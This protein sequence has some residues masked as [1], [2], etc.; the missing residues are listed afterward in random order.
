MAQHR[1]SVLNVKLIDNI[2]LLLVK[3]CLFD[4]KINDSV[5]GIYDVHSTHFFYN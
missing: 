5:K 2:T 1:V 4:L 3:A